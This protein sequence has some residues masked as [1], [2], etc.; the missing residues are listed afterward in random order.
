MAK[1]DT[2]RALVKR[3]ISEEVANLLV[4]DY[5]SLSAI[6]EAGVDGL[7]Q[8]GL[9]EGEAENV[10]TKVG[11]PAKKKAAKA[12]VEPADA[13]LAPVEP[14]EEVSRPHEYTETEERLFAIQEREGT[15][16]PMKIICDIAARI[17]EADLDDETCTK[18]ITTAEGMYSS[19][20]MDQNES[21]GVMAAHSI[22]EPG[23]QMNLRTFH[24]A[25]IAN[26]NVTQGLPRLIE[27]V[28]A[29]REPSTP[30]MN[31][32]L[33]GLATED[34]KMA[35]YVATSIEVTTLIDIAKIETDIT[36]M[37]LII[38]PDAKKLDDRGI[39][40][41]DVVERLNRVKAVRGLVSLDGYDIV[42]TSD[43]PSFKKLQQMHDAIKNSRIKGIDGIKRAV[44]VKDKGV[45]TIVTE[46][47]NL[48]EVLQIEGVDTERVVT[49]SIIEVADVLG[50][51]AARNSIVREAMGTLNAAGL[52]VDIRHIMLVA[53][54]MTN[55]GT[56]RAI[57]RHG[58]SGKKSS[59]LA[60][61]AFEITAAHLLHAA[62]VGEVD[63]LEGV[64]ENIIV[65]QPVTLG[66]GAVNLLY[67]PKKAKGDNE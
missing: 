43:E 24:F 56:V 65:G 7:V 1:K 44:V 10:I 59:V 28:D 42:V 63:H 36:N 31:I 17:A 20:L 11:R 12:A 47:S 52:D 38:K 32:P 19:H 55:D 48:K 6:A 29:R 58:V 41:G 37:R 54:L 46:G 25:G 18:L 67:T 13:P 27:I 30:S 51:E 61:A 45:F 16:L 15:R 14:L 21:A 33:K 35:R 26:I 62:M 8:S 64:T 53:D 9:T 34:D 49:N 2:I 22:G 60:R 4:K 40:V 50:I 57:G 23:T 5:S 66:T 3:E 39:T